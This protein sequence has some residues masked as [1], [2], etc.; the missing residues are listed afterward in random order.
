MANVTVYNKTNWQNLPTK[1]SPINASNLNHVEQGIY[2]VTQ[3]VNTLHAESGLYLSQTPFMN[4]DRTKLDNL[5]NIDIA[6]DGFI[7]L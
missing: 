7:Y 3:F 5:S 4:A 2:N 1:T 6:E